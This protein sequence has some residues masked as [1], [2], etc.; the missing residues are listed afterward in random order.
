MAPLSGDYRPSLARSNAWCRD[1]TRRRAENFT[2]ASW[3]LPRHLRQHFANVYA[4]CRWADDLADEHAAAAENLAA[5]DDWELQ[6][7]RCAAGEA[8]HPIYVALAE[9]L[10]EFALPLASFTDLLD[11]FRQDQRL[12]RYETFD[13]LLVYCRRSANPVGRIVLGLGRCANTENVALSDRICTGL[14]LVNFWQDVRRDW[15]E[16]GRI[17]LPRETLRQFGVQEQDL[18]GDLATGALRAAIAHEVQRAASFLRSG[19]PLVARVSPALRVEVELFLR[20]GLAVAQ[21]I[22]G[23][24][25]DILSRRPVVSRAKKLQLLAITTL[26]QKLLRRYGAPA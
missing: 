13:E 21:A 2:V 23:Q 18:A 10:R 4:W 24:N 1:F 7:Q 20:G 11:A 25:Y 8:A 16:R 17:Y 5:L 9:T 26:R 14:Q 19:W 22:R 15:N 12:A 3:L 6:L